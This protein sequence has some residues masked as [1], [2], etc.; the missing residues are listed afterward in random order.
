MLFK[1]ETGHIFAEDGS[2][3]LVAEIVFPT[4][5][6]GVVDIERTFVDPSLRGQGIA[7]QLMRAAVEDIRKTGAKTTVT[8]EY[9]QRWFSKHPDQ[10]DVLG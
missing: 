10:V 2:G 1:H 9:A 4:G 7:D 3:N 8:C 5:P 6:N